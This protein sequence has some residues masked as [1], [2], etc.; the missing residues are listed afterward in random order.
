MIVMIYLQTATL[1]T[2]MDRIRAK[3]NIFGNN[4]RENDSEMDSF[5]KTIIAERSRT[6]ALSVWQCSCQPS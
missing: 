1:Q 2:I 4:E 5:R 6:Q 3:I